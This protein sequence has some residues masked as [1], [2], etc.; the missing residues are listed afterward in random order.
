[1]ALAQAPPGIFAGAAASAAPTLPAGN[2]G[3]TGTGDGKE[4]AAVHDRLLVYLA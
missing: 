1:L 3:G 4:F 2:G